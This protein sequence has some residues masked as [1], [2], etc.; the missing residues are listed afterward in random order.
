M[1]DNSKEQGKLGA[2]RAISLL[3]VRV[4]ACFD[5]HFR[6]QKNMHTISAVVCIDFGNLQMH[7]FIQVCGFP[8][9]PTV[10]TGMVCPALERIS[11]NLTERWADLICL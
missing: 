10:S 11:S 2:V 1:K 4:F 6:A 9:L 3:P 8:A 5:W 7:V